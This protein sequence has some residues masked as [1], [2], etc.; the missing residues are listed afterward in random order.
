MTEAE[1]WIG[2]N[3]GDWGREEEEAAAGDWLSRWGGDQRSDAKPRRQPAE[4]KALVRI[5]GQN[6]AYRITDT[7]LCSLLTVKMTLENKKNSENHQKQPDI[8]STRISYETIGC[9]NKSIVSEL[10]SNRLI[11][12]VF[13]MIRPANAP[14]ICSMFCASHA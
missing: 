4:E 7:V 12:Q 10:F 8:S 9:A 14:P 6:R 1:A 11:L 2:R 5:A 13:T 3:R